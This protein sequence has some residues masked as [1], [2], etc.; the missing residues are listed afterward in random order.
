MS[1]PKW[2]L[3]DRLMIFR[4]RFGPLKHLKKTHLPLLSNTERSKHSLMSNAAGLNLLVDYLLLT[5]PESDNSQRDFQS[6]SLWKTCTFAAI[7]S[8]RYRTK[9]MC[10]VKLV[11]VNHEMRYRG[12]MFTYLVVRTRTSQNKRPGIQNEIINACSNDSVLERLVD[13]INRSNFLSVL[14]VETTDSSCQ[15]QLTL[16]PMH[17]P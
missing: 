1:D 11:F 2:I 7:I 5:A 17:R 10:D 9:R 13:S 3:R 14:T 12:N 4:D 16:C 8:K 15:A 6:F